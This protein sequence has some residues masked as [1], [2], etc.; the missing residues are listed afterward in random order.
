MRQKR[1]CV[2]AMSEHLLLAGSESVA[3]HK[4]NAAGGATAQKT[5]GKNNIVAREMHQTRQKQKKKEKKMMIMMNAKSHKHETN[6]GFD[7]QIIPSSSTELHA[8]W[9]CQ[10]PPGAV[11]ALAFSRKTHM[12]R[13]MSVCVLC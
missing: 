6:A 5:R 13:R 11:K 8:V 4:Q 10:V 9:C 12:F 1:G 3:A 7:G 2:W